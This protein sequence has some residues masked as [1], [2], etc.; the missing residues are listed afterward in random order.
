MRT[1]CAGVTGRAAASAF[2]SRQ[3]DSSD[4]SPDAQVVIC[5]HRHRC[6]HSRMRAVPCQPPESKPAV[7]MTCSSLSPMPAATV[8]MAARIDAG[9]Y[10]PACEKSKQECHRCKPWGLPTGGA[11]EG[12]CYRKAAAGVAVHRAGR[13]SRARPLP[14]LL[15]TSREPASTG[16][17]RP[18]RPSR[19]RSQPPSTPSTCLQH[20]WLTRRA[21][22]VGKL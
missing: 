3:D 15:R 10:R 5:S 6:R 21:D 1:R 22:L 17:Q 16:R 9:R 2:D 14:P 4:I 20:L 19:A 13:W 7:V 18:W 11:G 12:R 8:L